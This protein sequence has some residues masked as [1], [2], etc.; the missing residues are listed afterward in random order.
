MKHHLSAA[1]LVI[2]LLLPASLPAQHPNIRVSQPGSTDP[3]EVTIS[4][5]PTNP[6]NL[7]AGSNIDYVWYSFDGGHTWTEGHLT[8]PLGV[9]G[10]PCVIFDARGDLYYAHLSNPPG[11]SWLDRIVVQKSTD[12]GM[13]W[14]DGVGVGLNPPK[15]QDKE[16]LAADQTGS[17]YRHNLYMA[18]TEF[19]AYGSSN[20]ADSTRIL[21]SRSTDAGTTWS[22]PVRISDTAGNCLDGDDTVEGAVPAVG[23]NGEVYVSWSGPLGIMFDR[24]TDGGVS[25]GTDIFVTDQP[26][27]W[28]FDIFGISRCNGLPVTACDISSSAYQGRIYVLWS[29]QRNGVTDTDVFLISS[30][31]GG[32]TWGSI[33]RVNDDPA[34]RHQFFPWMTIDPTT[35][36][37]YVVFYDRRSTSGVATD[38]YLA[39]SEDGGQTFTNRL[40]SDSSFIPSAMVFFGDYINIAALNGLVY[41]IWMRMD[42]GDLSVWMA[43]MDMAPPQ[44]VDDL[45]A[46]LS[47]GAKSAAGDISLSW[48]QPADN[49]G[50]DHYVVYRST[51]PE[52]AIPGD[53]LVSLAEPFYLDSGVVGDTAVSH[54]Y[55]VEAVDEAG[56]R[57]GASNIVGEI[58]RGLNN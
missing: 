13:S 34:G 29:D 56:N 45:A 24:S 52:P 46:T 4:I 12:G 58:D 6:L 16:W 53:S 43:I 5:N 48:S 26:G 38:V 49:V 21:F 8:S 11:G 17:P 31:D 55:V 35:G 57:S 32:D 9:W 44:A 23:P 28:S 51:D 36:H 47:G 22:A 1:V 2:I 42:S 30:D 18:W 20:P 19:D 14:S 25:F 7:A 41:P 50:V 15:D 40:I 33:T 54:F 27:G 3:E 10:D 39:I 37:L